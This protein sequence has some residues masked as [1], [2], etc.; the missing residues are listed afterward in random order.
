[1]K[2]LTAAKINKMDVLDYLAYVK[3]SNDAMDT[4]AA[5]DYA[6]EKGMA[7]GIEKGIDKGIELLLKQEILSIELIADYATERKKT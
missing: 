3:R 6:E 2:A 5:L 4:E 7:K 1:M